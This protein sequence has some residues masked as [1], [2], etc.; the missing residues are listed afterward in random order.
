MIT[1]ANIFE[2][3]DMR[4]KAFKFFWENE[5]WNLFIGVRTGTDRLHHFFWDVYENESHVFH[6]RFLEYYK[7]VDDII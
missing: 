2:T 4:E 1:A 5:K 3:L 7:K 6:S